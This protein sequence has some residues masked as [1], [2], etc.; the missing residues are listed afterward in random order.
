MN[1]HIAMQTKGQNDK[2]SKFSIISIAS[3]RLKQTDNVD[4]QDRKTYC[5]RTDY[6]LGIY[7]INKNYS[8]SN[9]YVRYVAT[10][11]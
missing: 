2:K 7:Q 10:S 4:R 5:H 3:I 11:Y 1:N 9:R 8:F 6:I